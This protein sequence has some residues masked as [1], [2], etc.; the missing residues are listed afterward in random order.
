[1]TVLR[2]ATY[3]VHGAVGADGRYDPMR[4][5]K[6]IKAID[7]DILAVQEIDTRRPRHGG[8]NQF[9]LI[10]A[11]TGLTGVVGG[12]IRDHSGEYGNALF[13]RFKVGGS[14]R[15]DLSVDRREPRGALDV[16][17]ETPLGDIRVIAT[18]LGLRGAERRI[19]IDRLIGGL[20]GSGGRTLL[21]GDL[22]EWLPGSNR[23]LRRLTGRFPEGWCARTWPSRRP[24]FA[25]DRI[26]AAPKPRR[27][28]SLVWR[29]EGARSA[30][31]HLPFV[32]T[33]EW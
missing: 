4:I 3:N 28:E 30:S 6:I 15:I 29:T 19:Q 32:V 5:V 26:Y 10:G 14:R 17:L 16:E 1:M 2:V 21:L 9:E 25:L 11:E 8:L 20:G 24:I 23:R 12:N 13:T 27:A 33:M 7:P 18:H 31:D 22:N